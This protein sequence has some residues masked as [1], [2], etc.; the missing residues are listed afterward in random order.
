LTLPSGYPAPLPPLTGTGAT[1]NVVA[2][3]AGIYS[4]SFV[5][6]PTRTDCP[7]DPLPLPLSAVNV[8][9]SAA[10]LGADPT[11]IPA[12]TV[13]PGAAWHFS[14][15][16]VTWSPPECEGTLKILDFVGD[17]GYTPPNKGTLAPVDATKWRYTAFD[18]L[19]TELCPKAANVPIAAMQG[20]T[21]LA[22]VSI[23][24]LPV[25]TWWTTGHKHGS[26]THPPDTSDFT[27]D[28][29][30]LRWKYA[31]VLGTTGGAFAGP[32]TIGPDGSVYCGLWPLGTNGYACTTCIPLMGCSLNFGTSTFSASENQAASIIGHE[33]VHTTGGNECAAY[34]WERDAS[35]QTG[36]WFCDTPYLWNVLQRIGAECP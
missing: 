8:Q 15:I 23:R 34:S 28:Y 13:W 14:D 1:V 35:Q 36:I 32:P 22:R 26:Q 2:K 9:Q 33:L 16:T 20:N 7:P 5:A 3:V 19:Q 6:K 10:A 21:E 25:H 30:F 12:K 11:A 31:A 27:N 18:E 4:C 24:V 29:N 17:S